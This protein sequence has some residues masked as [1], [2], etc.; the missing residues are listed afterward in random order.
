MQKCARL[1]AWPVADMTRLVWPL[2]ASNFQKPGPGHASDTNVLQALQPGVAA[3]D[4][5]VFIDPEQCAVSEL[6]DI[7]RT[8]LSLDIGFEIRA[9]GN[10]LASVSRSPGRL[11][12]PVVLKGG[13]VYGTLW[14]PN[15]DR[16][17]AMGSRPTDALRTVAAL[18]GREVDR[19]RR[20]Y[21]S[22]IREHQCAAREYQ[23]SCRLVI[24]SSA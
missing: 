6:L 1:G 23:L 13:E 20:V 19:Y 8:V 15:D 4:C 16:R 5:G 7:A 22:W 14:C 3:N 21:F 18:L 2:R 24:A 10:S 17:T 12:T 11:N 9:Y